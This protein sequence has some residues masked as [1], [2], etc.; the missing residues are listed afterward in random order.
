MRHKQTEIGLSMSKPHIRSSVFIFIISCYF[1][2]AL[3]IT[4]WNFIYHHADWNSSSMIVAISILPIVIFTPLY[5]LF[6]LIT[7]PPL[8]KPLIIVLLLLSAAADYMMKNL[9]VVIDSSMIRNMFETNTR[10]ALDLVTMPAILHIFLFAVV[11]AFFVAY[12][13]IDYDTILK[14]TK[15]RLL[16]CLMAILVSALVVPVSYKEYVSYGRNNKKIRYYMNTFNYIA[17]SLRYYKLSHIAKHKF[18]IL[19]DNPQMLKKNN[20][21]PRVLIY[22][23]GETARAENFSLY[24]YSRETNPYLQ[25]QNVITFKN[26]TSCGTATTVSVP[27]MFSHQ[28][29]K[30]FKLNAAAYT[31]NLLDIL[32]TAGYEIFWRD[33][34]DGCKD[35]CNRVDNQKIQRGEGIPHCFKRYCYDEVLLEGLDQQIKDIK[36]DTVIVLHMMGSHG[37][38]YYQRYPAEFDQ[39][40]PACNTADLKDCSRQQ[41]IN[42]YDNTI[43]YTDYLLSSVIEILKKYPHLASAMLFVSD[44]GESLGENSIY[45]HGLPYAIAPNQQKQIP[46]ILWLSE[47]IKQD[48]AIDEKKLQENAAK[49]AYSHD[50][51]FHSLLHLLS[52]KTS[53]AETDRA[54][55]DIFL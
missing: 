12:V 13:K 46:M 43:L 34:D 16:W 9:G 7:F 31:Q 54:K 41:I 20:S 33:N 32:Q 40:K 53:V 6:N 51:L 29:R 48:V 18:I 28:T 8:A 39:F 21:S 55:L 30:K 25:Q 50:N 26:T 44:H 35:V 4:F 36:K 19:D 38:T 1:A 17:S 22:M 23:L 15:K 10:E 3:N 47:R 11:P 42:T 2:F 49:K 24:G 14:E 37:P 27:C 45:L 5:L 52:V